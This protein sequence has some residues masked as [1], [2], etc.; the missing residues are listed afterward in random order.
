MITVRLTTPLEQKQHC[1]GMMH[2][3]SHKGDVDPP[4]GNNSRRK[5]SAK[6]KTAPD[7]LSDPSS[8]GRT[9]TTALSQVHTSS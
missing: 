1:P 3:L 7:W 4:S 6:G 2:A 5:Q 8:E 9:V